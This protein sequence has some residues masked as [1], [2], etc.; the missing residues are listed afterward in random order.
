MSKRR[1]KDEQTRTY[2]SPLREAQA[3]QTRDR[4]LDALTTLLANRRADEITTRE[5]AEEAGV[6]QPTVYRHFADREALLAGVGDRLV[7]LSGDAHDGDPLHTLD[8]FTN[9]V[10]SR[11]RTAEEFAV[12][13]TAEALL[14]ADPRRFADDTRRTSE[15]LAQLVASEFSTLDPRDARALAGIMRC[16]GSAQTW[17]RLREEYDVGR[18][19]AEQLADAIAREQYERA[20]QLRDEIS[21][22]RSSKD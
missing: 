6:S 13:A 10:E 8:D 15:S 21:R 16:L 9:M 14:N 5:I 20:A 19:L 3:R 17:L 7:N 1:P 22:R 11:F 4:I 12:E 2:T 18:T